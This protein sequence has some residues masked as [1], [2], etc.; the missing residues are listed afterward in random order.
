V[1]DNM[2]A[3]DRIA[4]RAPLLD[5]AGALFTVVASDPEVTRYLSWLPHRTVDETRSV[6]TGLFNIGVDHTWLIILRRSGEL[7]GQIGYLVTAPHAVQVGYAL[8]RRFWGHGLAGEAL[9]LVVDQLRDNPALYRVAA[10]V[11]PDN[12]R[13]ARVLERAGFILEGRLARAI[14]FPGLATEPQDALLYG[15]ALR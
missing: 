1:A 2:I 5:D 11:H 10:S 15:M 7:I 12:H 6:I 14:L 13:S 8:G 4:L 3:G 9:Q